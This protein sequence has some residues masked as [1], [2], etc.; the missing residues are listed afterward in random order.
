MVYRYESGEDSHLEH[1]RPGTELSVISAGPPARPGPSPSRFP[2]PTLPRSSRPATVGHPSASMRAAHSTTYRVRG[3]QSAAEPYPADAAHPAEPYPP[4][5]AHQAEPYP[6]QTA[7]QAEPLPPHTAH[8]ATQFPPRVSHHTEP[9]PPHTSGRPVAQPL[10]PSRTRSSGGRNWQV[11]VGG[12]AV[13]AL[14]ALTGLGAA[15]LV[16]DRSSPPTVTPVAGPA[17]SPS[18]KSEPPQGIDSRETDPAPLT[19]K[20]VFG[21]QT[22]TLGSSGA[23]Y[24]VLKTQSSGS[25]AVAAT[26]EIADLLSLL[27]CSQV[28]RATLRSP[29]GEHLATAG[30]FNLTDLHTAERARDRIRELLDDRQG[31]LRGMPADDDE[32]TVLA[33][34]PAR[35][36]WQVR[37]HYLAYAVVTRADGAAADADDQTVRSVLFDLIE[38]HLNQ[39]V[40]ERRANAG[41][42]NQPTASPTERAGSPAADPDLTEDRDD[43]N[44]YDPEGADRSGDQD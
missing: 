38:L 31:R 42:A 13:L 24:Q 1:P 27:G 7:H 11:L 9:I 32:T 2:T 3:P 22:L 12:V 29:D 44:G 16:V 20:E 10:G 28:V 19:A 39:D 18:A 15:A 6:P 17:A 36:G 35:V 14:L 33:T 43:G 37:G 40:L 23:S 41:A 30:L 26:D 4:Q 21:S 8:Q 5:T 34:A 25:C